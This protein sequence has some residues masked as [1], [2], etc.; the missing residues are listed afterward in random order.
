VGVRVCEHLASDAE[1]PTLSVSIG[2]AIY[3]RDGESSEALLGSADR[4]LYAAKSRGGG[5]VRVKG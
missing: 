2:V 5:E 4:A 3:P 1:E